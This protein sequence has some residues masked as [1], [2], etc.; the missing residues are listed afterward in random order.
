MGQESLHDC[1]LWNILIHGL[2]VTAFFFFFKLN[3]NV[4]HKL[5]Y[6][7]DTC[8]SQRRRVANEGH[9]WYD[10]EQ[11]TA[12]AIQEVP[13]FFHKKNWF[14]LFRYGSMYFVISLFRVGD[15]LLV[16]LHAVI[17]NKLFN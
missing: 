11:I 12:A 13:D 10:S 5:C 8:F 16:E 6:V 14:D 1:T 9:P 7:K 4:S 15:I 2:Q 3:V 17:T